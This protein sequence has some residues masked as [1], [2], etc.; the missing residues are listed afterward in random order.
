MGGSLGAPR[1]IVATYSPRSVYGGGAGGP[2]LVSVVV[3]EMVP[4]VAEPAGQGALEGIVLS[5]GDVW[6]ADCILA[7]S[8]LRSPPARSTR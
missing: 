8:V 2:E 6:G 7:S 4:P 3:C 1:L 5:A